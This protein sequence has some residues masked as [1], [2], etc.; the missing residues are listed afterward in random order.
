MSQ[1][2]IALASQLVPGGAKERREVLRLFARRHCLEEKRVSGPFSKAEAA[3]LE[4]GE[5]ALA[6]V[7]ESHRAQAAERA[8]AQ[9]EEERRL[10]EA[11]RI[12]RRSKLRKEFNRLVERFVPCIRGEHPS[13]SSARVKSESIRQ[14][15][16]AKCLDLTVQK[17]RGEKREAFPELHQGGSKRVRPGPDFSYLPAGGLSRTIFSW[18]ARNLGRRG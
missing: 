11:A 7:F 6:L 3:L 1:G 2:D 12:V 14:A 10:Q 5:K 8:A 9:V 16:L 4:R 18:Y 15:R 13:W 17:F